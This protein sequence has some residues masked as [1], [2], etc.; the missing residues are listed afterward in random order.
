MAFSRHV[1]YHNQVRTWAVMLLLF[2]G[3]Q[4]LSRF[5][6]LGPRRGQTDDSV[7]DLEDGEHDKSNLQVGHWVLDK[8]VESAC[9]QGEEECRSC[10]R[11][12]LGYGCVLHRNSLDCRRR[13]RGIACC[14]QL[15]LGLS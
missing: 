15:A 9:H 5:H 12:K 1:A 8:R 3:T 2:P 7:R 13:L 6:L 4:F 11:E 14:G 10:W